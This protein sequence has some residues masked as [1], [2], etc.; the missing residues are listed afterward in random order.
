MVRKLDEAVVVITGASS[1]IGRAA[2]TEFARKGASLVLAARREDALEAL[3][4]DCETLGARAV[5]VRT[6][7]TDER[8]VEH[9]AERAI[10]AFGRIDVWVNNAA[11]TAFGPFEETPSEVFRRVVETN[12]FGYVYGSRAA[13]RRFREQGGGVL[14][15]VSSVVGHVAEAYT[16]AYSATKHAI[17]G[18]SES[19]R[20]ELME[21]QDIHVST[22]LP[23]SIDTPLFQQAAN[24]MGRA[25]K[26]LSPIYDPQAVAD[27]IVDAARKPKKEIFVGGAGA[28]ASLARQ[29]APDRVDRV[30]A[31]QVRKDHFTDA[32]AAPGSGNL[33][34]PMP[35]YT[36]ISGGWGGNLPAAR[37]STPPVVAFGIL[38]LLLALVSRF[39]GRSAELVQEDRRPLVRRVLDRF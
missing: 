4:R 35:Q 30:A 10:E 27:A 17:I 28:V 24:Y 39:I 37:I 11:V 3:A 2:A 23:A 33:F 32:P 8:Q 1:G 31:R 22:I 15:N 5:A 25:V 20:Q 29:I 16:T 13:V 6:D 38:L 19:L 9:L 18:F 26:P 7:V 34:D 12:F 21:E 36:G 14:I